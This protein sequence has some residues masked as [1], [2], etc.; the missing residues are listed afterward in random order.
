MDAFQRPWNEQLPRRQML[1]SLQPRVP[2]PALMTPLTEPLLPMHPEMPG[3]RHP[4]M[5][6]YMGSSVGTVSGMQRRK[7]AEL[8][9][10]GLSLST[11]RRNKPPTIDTLEKKRQYRRL[12]RVLAGFQEQINLDHS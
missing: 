9:D 5:H 6:V 4:H 8:S 1:L 11:N 7:P 10:Q 2:S 12:S 3:N